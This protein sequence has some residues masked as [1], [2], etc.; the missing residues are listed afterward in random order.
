[1]LDRV[2]DVILEERDNLVCASVVLGLARPGQGGKLLKR[3]REIQGERA[4]RR[5]KEN[6]QKCEGSIFVVVHGLPG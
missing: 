4:V 6:R 2:V 1:M 5:F 3:Q